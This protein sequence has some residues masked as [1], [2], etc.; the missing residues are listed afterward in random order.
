MAWPVCPSQV[1]LTEGLNMSN[2]D[3]MPHRRLGTLVFKDLNE[4]PMINPN[5]GA[6][7]TWGGKI[8]DFWQKIHH[9]SKTEYTIGSFCEM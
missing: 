4:I 2:N 3:S 5:G 1:V 9:I 7:Y 6:K 8:C